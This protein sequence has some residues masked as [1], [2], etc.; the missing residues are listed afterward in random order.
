VYVAIDDHSR[1]AF[2]SVHADERGSTAC[3]ALLAA[4]AYCKTLEVTFQRVLTDN[5]A[6]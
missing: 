4:L 6:C 3:Q 1:V 5:G 2:G